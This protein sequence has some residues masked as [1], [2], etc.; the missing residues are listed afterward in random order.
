LGKVGRGYDGLFAKGQDSSV[1]FAAS[2][3]TYRRKSGMTAKVYTSTTFG[4]GVT[5]ERINE[6][7]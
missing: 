1:S 6:E 7:T 2:P 4:L 3:R 5:A